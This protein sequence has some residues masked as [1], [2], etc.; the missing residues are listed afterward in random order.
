MGRLE[1]ECRA[2]RIPCIDR[3]DGQILF[4]LAS[5]VA[6]GKAEPLAVDAGSGVGYSTLWI[7]E[8]FRQ[9]CGRGRV[10][11]MDRGRDNLNAME[12][13]YREAGLDSFVEPLE[14]DAVA[15]LKGIH[16]P[17][18]LIFVDIEKHRYIEL[19]E[20]VEHRIVPGGFLAAHNIYAPDPE[21]G[22]RFVQ[23]LRKRGWKLSVAPTRA[24]MAIAVRPLASRESTAAY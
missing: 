19:F 18:D 11:A 24:G 1:E 23:H 13:I 7:V 9:G 8:G 22:S 12:E 3:E 21:E 20:V 5:V 4:A 14:G 2:R 17:I 10:I 6:A 15:L 16:R